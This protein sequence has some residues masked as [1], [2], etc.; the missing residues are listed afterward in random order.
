MKN[1]LVIDF[2]IT[3]EYSTILMFYKNN[4]FFI[5]EPIDGG[6]EMT[7]KLRLSTTLGDVKLPV[8]SKD[9]IGV[10]KKKLQVCMT[11]VNINILKL[12]FIQF[13][14]VTVESIDL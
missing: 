8:Y 7:L 12:S 10:A 5:A 3:F 13:S 9:T 1:K 4:N 14:Y 2:F 6:T 11:Y